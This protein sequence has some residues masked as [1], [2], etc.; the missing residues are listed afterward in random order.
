MTLFRKE[1]ILHKRFMEV[2][3]PV[4]STSKSD[5]HA[6][7]KATLL[8]LLIASEGTSFVVSHSYFGGVHHLDALYKPQSMRCFHVPLLG[9]RPGVRTHMITLP[10]FRLAV[11]S[12]A[13]AAS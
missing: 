5:E 10:P 11:L 7:R 12:A 9:G 3:A 8:V 4:I 13:I 6:P 1:N 2:L